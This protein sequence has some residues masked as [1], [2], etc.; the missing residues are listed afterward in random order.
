VEKPIPPVFLSAIKEE[1]L[2]RIAYAF[3][4]GLNGKEGIGEPN[5][6]TEDS[7]GEE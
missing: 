5:T 7:L 4:I 1:G 6:E 3:L 2:E